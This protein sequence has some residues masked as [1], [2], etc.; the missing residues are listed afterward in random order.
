MPVFLKRDGVK[1]KFP[2]WI[3]KKKLEDQVIVKSCGPIILLTIL[4]KTKIPFMRNS[5]TQLLKTA[6]NYEENLC[7]KDL[8]SNYG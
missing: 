1:V 4:F 5:S 6:I 8:E 2:E 3:K 7:E